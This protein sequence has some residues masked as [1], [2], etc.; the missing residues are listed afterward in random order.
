MKGELPGLVRAAYHNKAAMRAVMNGVNER[1]TTSTEEIEELRRELMRVREEALLD[2]L[3]GLLNRRAFDERITTMVADAV[4]KGEDFSLIMADIDH[5]K[6]I[7]DGYGPLFGD[8]VI[9]A[10][11]EALK[12]GVKGRDSVARYGGE[13][14][15]ILLPTTGLK[16]AW[17]VAEG[18]RRLV[19][20]SRIRR[21]NNDEVVGNITLSAG[22][23]THRD[24]EPIASLIERADAALYRAKGSGRNRVESAE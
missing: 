7:N 1:L 19:A 6:R 17:A 13:E 10:V 21:M 24:G 2:S 22:V 14:F 5:F 20:A 4:E 12:A 9:R 23:A 15:A 11:G 16:G 18:V 3:T 8:R